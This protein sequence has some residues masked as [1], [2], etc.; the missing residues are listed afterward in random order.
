MKKLVLVILLFS[1]VMLGIDSPKPA[2]KS[3]KPAVENQLTAEEKLKLDNIKLRF[4]NLQLQE[5]AVIQKQFGA[6]EDQLN[7]ENQK[8]VQDV[9]AAHKL[10]PNK[11]RFNE[12]TGKIE[13]V[14]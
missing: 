7:G 8:F 13:P 5:Q 6:V 9:L 14:K 4:E 1:S 12:G 3:D 11:Y 2:A 10:D